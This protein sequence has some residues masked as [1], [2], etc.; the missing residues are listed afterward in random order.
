MNDNQSKV[1]ALFE[2]VAAQ[3]VPKEYHH[4]RVYSFLTTFRF[5]FVPRPPSI[6]EMIDGMAKSTPQ[7]MISFSEGLQILSEM[8][9]L[10]KVLSLSPGADNYVAQFT[11]HPGHPNAIE[12]NQEATQLAL[13]VSPDVA[14]AIVNGGVLTGSDNLAYGV[15][16]NGVLSEVIIFVENEA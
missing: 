9:E 4:V 5:G 3:P 14:D 15:M 13:L 12:G 2:T 7:T 1:L 8:S 16:R 6:R 10:G 11:Q